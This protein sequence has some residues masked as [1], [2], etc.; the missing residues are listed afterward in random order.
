MAQRDMFKGH[1]SGA[2]YVVD[3]LLRIDGVKEASSMSYPFWVRSLPLNASNVTMAVNSQSGTY[4]IQIGKYGALCPSASNG[5]SYLK[6]SVTLNE[7]AG[8]W[9]VEPRAAFAHME[10]SINSTQINAPDANWLPCIMASD[11]ARMGQD[12]V[13]SYGSL[14]GLQSKTA[15]TGALIDPTRGIPTMG[16]QATRCFIL[17]F[18][19]GYSILGGGCAATPVHL[20]H[21]T[22]LRYIFAA[23]AT[24][25][26]RLD[27]AGQPANNVVVSG[28]E[29]WTPQC[30]L[31]PKY[32]AYLKERLARA[33]VDPSAGILIDTPTQE[34]V[35][36]SLTTNA[37]ATNGQQLI[38]PTTRQFVN[39]LECVFKQNGVAGLDALWKGCGSVRAYINKIGRAHV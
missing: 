34:V 32:E 12:W 11:M 35:T 4:D 25:I 7:A 20:L 27:A 21:Q 15:A 6:F 17:H 31:E 16:N 2:E 23:P 22:L 39:N 13:A 26:Q 29:L 19:R 1:P 3:D 37:V 30:Q 14:E 10:L 24:W 9:G 36:Q 18:P 38:F 8:V 5:G 33:D 28:V